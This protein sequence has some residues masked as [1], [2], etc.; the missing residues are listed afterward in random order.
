MVPKDAQKSG[1]GS[2]SSPPHALMDRSSRFWCRFMCAK[3][4][5]SRPPPPSFAE[6][7]PSGPDRDSPLSSGRD[8]ETTRPRSSGS[9][10]RFW[11]RSRPWS[12]VSTRRPRC[13]APERTRSIPPVLIPNP[14][15]RPAP[16]CC[17]AQNKQNPD[18][19]RDQDPHCTTES[20]FYL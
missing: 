7:E 16:R 8:P 15:V 11:D 9:G 19:N 20:S 12:S 3:S 1:A 6:P 13:V 10:Q 14:C 5:S 2:V 4:S 18:Q 17:T